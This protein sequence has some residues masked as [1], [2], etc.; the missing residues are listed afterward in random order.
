MISEE[1][2]VIVNTASIAASD[3]QIG[4]AAYAAS[5]SGVVGMTLFVAR[6]LARYGIRVMTM[7]PSL[8]LTP[9]VQVISAKAHASETTSPISQPLRTP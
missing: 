8:F 6:E 2:G 3:G 4:Q 7:A 1:C 9:M 5:K